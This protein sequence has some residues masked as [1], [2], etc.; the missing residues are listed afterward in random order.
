MIKI[1]RKSHSIH[2]T[3]N[4]IETWIEILHISRFFY[5]TLQKASALRNLKIW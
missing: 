4:L 3:S 5:N 2:H 1:V